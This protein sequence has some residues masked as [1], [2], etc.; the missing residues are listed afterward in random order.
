MHMLHDLSLSS[1]DLNLLVVL[2]ALLR[3]RHVTRAASSVGL[4]QSA[5]SHALARLRELCDDPL[6]VRHGRGLELTPRAQRLLPGLE[7]GL[8]DLQSVVT[9][10]PVFDPKT[11]RRLFTIGMA[12][13]AQAVLLAPLLRELQRQAPNIDLS[14]V[15][16]PNL[17]EMLDAGS[18]DVALLLK[19]DL[20]A[21]SFSTRALFDDGFVCMMRKGHPNAKAKLTLET[22]LSMRHV[23]V[24]PGGS[25]GSFVDSELA[26]RGLER[27][28]ALRVSSFLVA[29][30]VV[31][32]TDFISTAPERLARRMARRFPLQ[33]LAPPL[34]LPGFGLCLAWHPRFDADP[35][36]RWLR[37][38]VARV[39]DQS[40]TPHP[41][42][43]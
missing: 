4:S 7:R 14:V 24:A 29:P 22:Y 38:F 35:A 43:R 34:R 6:L 39:S 33:L 15:T 21:S 36:H 23:L 32:E 26:R 42:L 27:R 30:I 1:V 41:K 12:D 8:S 40:D 9:A 18:L 25:P 16:F 10:E 19:G 31:S 13:Y 28:I 20:Q 5:T 17:V 11:A 3:E 2:R 37:E